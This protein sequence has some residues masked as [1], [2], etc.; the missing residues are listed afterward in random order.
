MHTR[1]FKTET[2]ALATGVG[3]ARPAASTKARAQKKNPGE[4]ASASGEPLW[5][6]HRIADLVCRKQSFPRKL[7]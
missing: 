5:C 6:T 3:Y 7:I 1:L 4:P 2:Q